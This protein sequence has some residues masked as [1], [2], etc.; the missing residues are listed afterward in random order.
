MGVRKTL[1]AGLPFLHTLKTRLRPVPLPRLEFPLLSNLITI[2]DLI[3]PRPKEVVVAS[4]IGPRGVDGPGK[5][6]SCRSSTG[7]IGKKCIR[8]IIGDQSPRCEIPLDVPC[9][10][11]R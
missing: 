10:S 9:G 7:P 2:R 6:G 11:F 4:T 1:V 5:Q 8:S 3:T